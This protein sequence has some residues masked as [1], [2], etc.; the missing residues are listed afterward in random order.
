MVGLLDMGEAGQN[1][2]QLLTASAAPHQQDPSCLCAAAMVGKAV[3]LF[4]SM[5][6]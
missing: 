3:F 2:P 1:P 5:V 4:L 6:F